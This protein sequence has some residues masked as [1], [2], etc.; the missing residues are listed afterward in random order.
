M[1]TCTIE[2]FLWKT[3]LFPAVFSSGKA[4]HCF[5]NTLV[6]GH[7][8]Q[9]ID[10]FV[11]STCLVDKSKE[12]Q[13]RELPCNLSM[14]LMC[15]ARSVKWLL[16][17]ICLIS[18]MGGLYV[19]QSVPFLLLPMLVI[20]KYKKQNTLCINSPEGSCSTCISHLCTLLPYFCMEKQLLV[21]L[22]V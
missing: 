7:T 19:M 1:G 3:N 15:E 20:S 5:L 4:A 13:L 21:S 17:L 22:S 10:P 6:K 14:G 16:L 8:F 11:Q 9:G 12:T 18:K 2:R